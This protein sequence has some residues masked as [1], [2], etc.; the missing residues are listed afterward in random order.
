MYTHIKV[1][2]KGVYITRACKHGVT[3]SELLL[4]FHNEMQQ[5]NTSQGPKV[6]YNVEIPIDFNVFSCLQEKLLC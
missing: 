6:F 1:G 5:I 3:M 2:C 4:V